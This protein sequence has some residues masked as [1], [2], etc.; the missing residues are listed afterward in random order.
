MLQNRLATL[1]IPMYA[2]EVAYGDDPFVLLPGPRTLQLRTSS[3][4]YQK[5]R[6]YNVLERRVPQRFTKLLFLDSDVLLFNTDPGVHW[7]DEVSR[8]L[9]HADVLHPPALSGY[10]DVLMARATQVKCSVLNASANHAVEPEMLRLQAGMAWGFRRNWLQSVGGL[11]DYA[12]FGGGDILN[13]AAFA[14]LPVCQAKHPQ[15]ERRP[16]FRNCSGAHAAV[17]G[18][19]E[20]L[21]RDYWQRVK[22]ASPVTVTS[23]SIIAVHFF[24]GQ[25]H[26]RWAEPTLLSNANVSHVSQI[27]LTNEDDIWVYRNTTRKG[28]RLNA[29]ICS[30]MHDPHSQQRRRNAPPA[31]AS[32]QVTPPIFPK[33]VAQEIIRAMVDGFQQQ[34][35][36]M[37]ALAQQPP[38]LPV[39]LPLPL[40]LLNQLPEELPR[41]VRAW[42]R[43]AAAAVLL[44]LACCACC[45]V[46]VRQAM[47]R[48]RVRSQSRAG[49]AGGLRKE[50]EK[51]AAWTATLFPTGNAPWVI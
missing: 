40:P 7:Y 46:R 28:H 39:P 29:T 18:S 38:P 23:T 26:G 5:E 47:R 21:Y 41:A 15:S 31:T 8:L 10:L 44:P 24:H 48:R 20:E 22:A 4:M 49:G 32:P 35:G 16:P 45:V 51:L 27:L 42:P 36:M 37:A 25:R 19:Y 50:D 14:Q 13:A 34:P 1:K 3:C 17:D 33:E 30:Y 11:F 9:E 2:V 43:L 6:L 12:V